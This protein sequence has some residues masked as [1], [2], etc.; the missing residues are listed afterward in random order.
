[1]VKFSEKEPRKSGVV[2]ASTLEQIEML[3]KQDPVSAGELAIALLELTLK[4]EYD[5]DNFYVKLVLKQ[6]ETIV[7]RDKDRYTA[8][9]ANRE[10]FKERRLKEVAQLH[11]QGLNQSQIGEKIGKDRTTVSK[12]LKDIRA[13]HPEWLTPKDKTEGGSSDE[14][15]Q[16]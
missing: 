16:F 7:E 12:Y 2:Y 5:T 11:L 4:G 9:C 15:F 3:Y 14:N 6:M 1:M 8:T 13:Y 10:E